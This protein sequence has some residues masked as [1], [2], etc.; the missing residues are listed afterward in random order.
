MKKA[1]MLQPCN[2]VAFTEWAG[3]TLHPPVLAELV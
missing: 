1:T 3:N 2:L